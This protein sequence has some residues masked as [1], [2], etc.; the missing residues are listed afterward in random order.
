[1]LSLLRPTATRAILLACLLTSGM[2]YYYFALLL[3]SAHRAR[4][5]KGLNQGYAF[6]SDFYAVWL[7]SHQLLARRE[8]PYTAEMV[9]KM[10]LGLYGR[11]LDP[12]RSGEPAQNFARY[13]YPLYLDLLVAP[14]G[15]LSFQTA[16]IVNSVLL[17]I[18]FSAAVLLWLSAMNF[19]LQPSNLFVLLVLGLATYPILEGL[20]ALQVS[21]IVAALIASSAASLVGGR[22][23]LAGVLLAIASVK[24][25]LILLPALF[26]ALW[27]ASDWKARKPFLLFFL[28][29]IALLF[30]TSEAILPGWSA[31][32]IRTLF[33]YRKYNDP[34]LTRFLFGD[35]VGELLA[36]GL[37]CAAA[38]LAFRNRKENPNSPNFVRTLVVVLAITV[39]TLPSTIAVYDQVLLLPALLWLLS[40]KAQILRG[41]MP[42]RFVGYLIVASVSWQWITASGLALWSLLF[43]EI[44]NSAWTVLPLRLTPALPFV[45]I[46]I[47][48]LLGWEFKPAR[49]PALSG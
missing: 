26:L 47:Y 12:Q 29:T 1:M 45:V 33:E 38:V 7:T 41:K 42:V 25:Q 28:G 6:G 20:Y 22:L 14:L 49:S 9:R 27:A 35:I 24:P 4:T 43:R 30:A 3:P 17:P 11:T 40:R 21:L 2:T 23:A 19:R 13:P 15:G 31:T 36:L 39:P 34:P 16:R 37:I 48:L 10:Q 18:L 46:A 8:S 5:A 32:W 44:P